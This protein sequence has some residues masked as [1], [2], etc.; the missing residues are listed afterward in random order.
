MIKVSLQTLKDKKVILTSRIYN[1]LGVEQLIM[2]PISDENEYTLDAIIGNAEEVHDII[3]ETNIQDYKLSKNNILAYGHINLKDNSKDFL[4]LETLKLHNFDIHKGVK[5]PNNYD[6][7]NHCCYVEKG[8][9]PNYLNS[10]TLQMDGIDWTTTTNIAKVIQ[11]NHGMLGKPNK[12]V[13]FT[14]F[15]YNKK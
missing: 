7:E 13:I 6:Y 2:I 1:G 5:I 14:N 10:P 8:K 3:H 4:S 15:I 11:Y 9:R 12:V